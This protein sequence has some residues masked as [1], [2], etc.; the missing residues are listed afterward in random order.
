MAAPVILSG[1]KIFFRTIHLYLSLAAGLVIMVTCVTGA[2]LVFERE[3]QELFNPGRYYVEKTG[4]R[5]P[6]DS[7]VVSLQSKVKDAKVNGIKYY[8]DSTRTVELS[9]SL[10]KAKTEA[11]KTETKKKAS[12]GER[13]IAFVNPY[14]AEVIDLYNYKNTFFYSVMDLHRWM[15]SGDTG[16]LIVGSATFI[17]LFILTTGL[18]LW[19]PK[20]RAILKQRLKLKTDGGWKRLN[21]DLHIVF[22]FYSFIFLF[23]FAFTG[24]AW[25]FEWFNKAIYTVTGSSMQPAKPPVV[26]KESNLTTARWPFVAAEGVTGI[27]ATSNLPYNDIL[28]IASDQWPEAR[29]YNI[30]APKDSSAAYSVSLLSVNAIHES[31]TDIYY[32]HPTTGAVIGSMKWSERNTGQRV[33]ATFKP[34]HVASIYGMPSKVVGLIVC[35]FG[36]SFPVTGVIMWVNRLKKKKPVSKSAVA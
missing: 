21:H 27:R 13:L 25:S 12:E 19:W 30:S 4:N 17:F 9:Y 8:A 24:L 33:R 11:K 22:G 6:L 20:S 1:M 14:T 3:L 35:L 32:I 10:K 28:Q 15:L 36:A 16:K 18:I 5:V 7:M 29:F 2:I 31:A 34:V 26:K 23:I